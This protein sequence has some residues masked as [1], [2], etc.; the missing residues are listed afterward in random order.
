MWQFIEDNLPDYYRRNDVLRDDILYRFL[1]GEEVCDD[2]LEWIEEEF[3]G[4]KNMVAEE[5]RRLEAGFISESLESYYKN[6]V[7]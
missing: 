4:D 1:E 7:V 6:L 2:D 5:L 3:H